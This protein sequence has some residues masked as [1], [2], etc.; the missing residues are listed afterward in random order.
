MSE[1]KKPEIQKPPLAPTS[2]IP[3]QT[4][5]PIFVMTIE[6]EQGKVG[7]IKIYLIFISVYDICCHFMFPSNF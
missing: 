5:D 1:S 4:P 6:L 2:S 3:K 7:N